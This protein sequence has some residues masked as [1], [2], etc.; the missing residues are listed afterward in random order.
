[1]KITPDGQ[2][3]YQIE[4]YYHGQWKPEYEPWV[5]LA[6]GWLSSPD[7]P[8][9]AWNSA[10]TYDMIFTQPVCYEFGDLDVPTLLVVGSLDRTALGRQWAPDD[11]KETLGDYPNL[12]K[13][14]ASEIAGCQLE[15]LEGVG[16]VPQIEAPDILFPILLKFLQDS[17]NEP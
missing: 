4:S 7:Y 13:S 12:A 9:V 16:H 14:A 6:T 10:L 2:K 1:L 5:R 17:S 11:V 8:N 3:K 15:I